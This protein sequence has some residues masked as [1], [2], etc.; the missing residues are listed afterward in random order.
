MD[1]GLTKITE[2]EIEDADPLAREDPE[3]I[4]KTLEEMERKCD[5]SFLGIRL[6]CK[7]DTGKL[8][9]VEILT[10]LKKKIDQIKR[11]ME[12]QFKAVGTALEKTSEISLRHA[13][14]QKELREN[15]QERFH[16]HQD[17]I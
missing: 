17:F 2:T 3:S 4:L 15:V 9:N 12:E 11:M 1:K 16:H 6:L 10:K 14:E 8:H 7:T 5:S 13:N